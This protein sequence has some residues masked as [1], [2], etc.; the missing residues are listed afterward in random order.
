MQTIYVSES[1]VPGCRRLHTTLGSARKTLTGKLTSPTLYYLPSKIKVHLTEVVPDM[2]LRPL[3]S[4]V[5]WPRSLTRVQWWERGTRPRLFG[6]IITY[7]WGSHSYK[8][9]LLKYSCIVTYRIAWILHFVINQMKVHVL[10]VGSCDHLCEH[11]ESCFTW[12][13]CQII[14]FC[15]ASVH[16]TDYNDMTPLCL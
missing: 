9:N 8:K 12:Y 5:R 13:T 15:H 2:Q 16:M 4:W 14:P 1:K 3:S 7:L 6:A 11:M 10:G